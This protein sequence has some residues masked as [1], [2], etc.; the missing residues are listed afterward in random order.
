MG[1]NGG[2]VCVVNA[3]LNYYTDE[4]HQNTLATNWTLP[5]LI[6]L[7]L[8]AFGF[9]FYHL[10]VSV[11][12]FPLFFLC[13]S[14]SLLSVSSCGEGQQITELKIEQCTKKHK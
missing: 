4:K 10:F 1:L 13:F 2:F 8:A 11:F 12:V 6:V 5:I 3:P 7:P 14:F 9:I